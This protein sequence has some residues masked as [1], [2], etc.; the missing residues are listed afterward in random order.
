MNFNTKVLA[1]IL[2]LLGLVSITK[3]CFADPPKDAQLIS[4]HLK[5]WGYQSTINDQYLKAEN[6]ETFSTIYIEQVNPGLLFSFAISTNQNTHKNPNNLI[7]LLNK[8]N[9]ETSVIK[10]Y[11]NDHYDINGNAIYTGEYNRQ[12]FE[13]F[14]H[15]YLSD[16]LTFVKNGEEIIKYIKDSDTGLTKNPELKDLDSRKETP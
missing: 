10:L 14:M 2:I 6:T 11:V 12:E 15:A 9:R 16:T 4:D 7:I 13:L 5:L 3:P 8:I 1:H